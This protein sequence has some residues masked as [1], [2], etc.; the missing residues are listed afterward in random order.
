[1]KKFVTVS[2]QFDVRVPVEA[3]TDGEAE[4]KINDMDLQSIL[5]WSGCAS[6]NL[7]IYGVEDG[8]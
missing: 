7:N 5:E 1:M 6:Y 8:T 3:E 2:L 4:D